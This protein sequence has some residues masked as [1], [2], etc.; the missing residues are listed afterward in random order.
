MLGLLDAP[1]TYSSIERRRLQGAVRKKPKRSNPDRPARALVVEDTVDIRRL[2]NLILEDAGLEVFSVGDGNSAADLI[3]Q[4]PAPDLVI[5]DRMLPYM[6]GEQLIKKIRSDELWSEVPVVVVSAKAR[7]DEISEMMMDG[8]DG[9]ITKPFNA[10][11]FVEVVNRF[12]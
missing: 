10:K 6:S 9:Y 4:W 5:L 2:M 3:M 1:K 12:I 8:A 7:G 11:H